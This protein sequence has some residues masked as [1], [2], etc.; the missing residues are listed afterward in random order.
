MYKF[1]GTIRK[2]ETRLMYL[3]EENYENSKIRH[4]RKIINELNIL[5]GSTRWKHKTVPYKIDDKMRKY[6]FLKNIIYR[7]ILILLS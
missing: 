4:K 2:P 6:L 1:D 5:T 7:I 3:P